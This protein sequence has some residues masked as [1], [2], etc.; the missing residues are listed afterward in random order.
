M[1]IALVVAVI[2]FFRKGGGLVGIFRTTPESIPSGPATP[3]TQEEA[4]EAREEISEN[5]Q[6]E[7]DVICSEADQLRKKIEEKF[8]EPG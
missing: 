4:E 5:L 2:L 1:V 8:G 3:I 7:E 6:S